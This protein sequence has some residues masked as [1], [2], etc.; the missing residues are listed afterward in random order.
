M[1]RIYADFNNKDP[2]GYVRLNTIGTIAD[3]A[4]TSILLEDGTQFIVCDG[5]LVAGIIVRSSG[6]EGIWRGEVIS[7]PFEI[8]DAGAERLLRESDIL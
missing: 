5:D 1:K 8:H 7:G 2:D 6:A 4:R 3:L